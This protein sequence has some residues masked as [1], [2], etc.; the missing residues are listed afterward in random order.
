MRSLRDLR[1]LG[2]GTTSIDAHEST[3]L[4]LLPVLSEM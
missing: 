4:H 1:H 3:A 2:L